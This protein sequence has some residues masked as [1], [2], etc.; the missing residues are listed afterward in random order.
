MRKTFICWVIANFEIA[1]FGFSFII[2]GLWSC[3]TAG[4]KVEVI[5]SLLISA[6]LVQILTFPSKKGKFQ[7]GR[8]LFMT[9]AGIFFTIVYN[10][11]DITDNFSEYMGLL[12]LIQGSIL[13]F[14]IIFLIASLISIIPAIYTYRH[15]NEVIS[16]RMSYRNSKVNLFE[17]SRLYTLDRFCSITISII[18]C[19]SWFFI[20]KIIILM[21]EDIIK[22]STV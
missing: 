4:F 2:I 17:Y 8:Y 14:W 15:I 6:S 13:L 3:L 16:R 19:S 20:M 11:P 9:G 5:I 12:M 18:V 22:N 10:L 7:F 1:I 21:I